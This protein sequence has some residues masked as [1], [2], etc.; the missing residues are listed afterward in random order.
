MK[1]FEFNQTL[2]CAIY[3]Y[4]ETDEKKLELWMFLIN[5]RLGIYFRRLDL[6]KVIQEYWT[7]VFCKVR[8]FWKVIRDLFKEIY[9]Q[10]VLEKVAILTSFLFG[11]LAVFWGLKLQWTW[12]YGKMLEAEALKYN[13]I[14]VEKVK[15]RD[16]TWPDP[17]LPMTRI[18]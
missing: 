10:K 17:S 14:E 15:T 18:K 1:E 8:W 16:G 3:V 2:I 12:I 13:F 5:T 9:V 11:S 4:Y 7:N 6:R